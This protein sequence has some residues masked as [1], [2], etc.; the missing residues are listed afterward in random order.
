MKINEAIKFKGT[1]WDSTGTTRA[2]ELYLIAF[3][4]FNG[5]C[6][7]PRRALV[8]WVTLSG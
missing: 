4:K 2:L 5:S 1:H 8:V 3:L 7:V 6:Y